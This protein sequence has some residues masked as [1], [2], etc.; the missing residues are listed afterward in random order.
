[1]DLGT[2]KDLAEYGEVPYHLIDIADAGSEYSVFE[3]Q[4]DCYAALEDIW[5]R[6]RTPLRNN[7]V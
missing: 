1:M 3:F 6:Q 4:R 7:F 2:G 5:R